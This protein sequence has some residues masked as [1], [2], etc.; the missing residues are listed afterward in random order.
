MA[1]FVEKEG[2][3][4]EERKY[5]GR[6]VYDPLV[7]PAKLL[8]G[9]LLRNGVGGVIEVV[10]PTSWIFGPPSLPSSTTSIPPSLS[11]TPL[12]SSVP[13]PPSPTYPI[14]FTHGPPSLYTGL[15]LPHSSPTSLLSLPPHLLDLPSLRKRKVWGTDVYTDDSDVL[16]MLVHSGWLRVGRREEGKRAGEKGA[17][18]EALRRAREPILSGKKDEMEGKEEEEVPKALLVRLGVVP[19]LVRYQG[20]ERQGVKS[21]SW[22]NGHDGVSLRVEAVEG[23]EV[24]FLFSLCFALSK[25]AY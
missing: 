15:P 17:G 9:E 5:L 1:S 19:P 16:G 8:D 10:V 25:P 18:A 12:R 13:P 22:G 2:E 24:R 14:T 4:G 23:I 20:L 11:A 3:G 21:R 7:E 6:V